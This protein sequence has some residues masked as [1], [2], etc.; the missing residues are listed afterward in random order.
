MPAQH[1]R[2]RYA[3]I[4]IAAI[5]CCLA[6]DAALA[7]S[8]GWCPSTLMT[9]LLMAPAALSLGVL[10]IIELRS[11]RIF[12][13]VRA[14]VL[15][16]WICLIV[17]AVVVVEVGCA[18]Y[19]ADPQTRMFHRKRPGKYDV[20]LPP[21][22]LVPGIEKK[23]N[24][25]VNSRGV[26]GPEM[27]PRDAAFRILC[28]GGRT[29]ENLFLDDVDTWP[30]LLMES[31]NQSRQARAV[32]VGDI[33]APGYSSFHHLRFLQSSDLA[34]EIHCVVILMSVNDFLWYAANGIDSDPVVE[35]ENRQP[36]SHRLRLVRMTAY[37]GRALKR[38]V[39]WDDEANN[40]AKLRQ[41]RRESQRSDQL[42]D[43]EEAL[44]Q[45]R[46]RV[47]RIVDCCHAKNITPVFMTEPVLWDPDLSKEARRLLFAG[48]TR[49]DTGPKYLTVATLRQGMDAYNDALKATCRDLG[50]NCVDL[51]SMNGNAKWFY[52]DC[53]YAPAGS[54]EV[55]R[56]ISDW[57][58]AHP[59]IT[60]QASPSITSVEAC[61]PGSR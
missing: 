25:T 16:R 17:I 55:G 7:L 6:V 58:L 43:L 13:G 42:P 57:F 53:H 38:S 9:V 47:Q 41:T 36:L 22:E 26:R 10:C 50:V 39:I 31:L 51:V 32:W 20:I 1:Y 23:P 8:R 49:H 46:G 61:P 27:A 12:L 40:L 29:T 45:Y 59:E 35:E 33:G 37:Y 11:P 14:S 4:A 44:A 48:W 30:H 34:E 15:A 52:D 19:S 24:Y 18:Y 21:L 54:R 5:S 2:M 60:G 28:I 3:A 56:I